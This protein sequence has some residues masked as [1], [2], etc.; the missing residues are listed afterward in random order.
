M[1]P[2]EGLLERVAQCRRVDAATC[3]DAHLHGRRGRV[4]DTGEQQRIGFARLFYHSPKYALAD[5]ATSALD[6]PLQ[7]RCLDG[8]K[9]RGIALV[10]VGHR[11][12]LRDFHDKVL[13]LDGRGGARLVGTGPSS[14]TSTTRC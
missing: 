7:Q 9:S 1:I 2:R 6:A 12:E 3:A 8:C 5:E 13:T 10:S 4:L 14:G 11:P